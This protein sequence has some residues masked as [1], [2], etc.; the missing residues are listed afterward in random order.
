[1]TN[2]LI[3][4]EEAVREFVALQNPLILP[5][6]REYF[7][8]MRDGTKLAEYRLVTAYWRRRLVGRAFSHVIIT[9]GYPKRD[10]TARR[11][12]FPW[13]GYKIETIQHPHF[14]PAPVSVFAITVGA[15]KEEGA[16]S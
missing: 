9:L 12:V 10:D 11:L 7:E 13:R 4:P 15:P 14:G 3:T 6:K 8:Q 16:Q 5:V 1:M 2:S